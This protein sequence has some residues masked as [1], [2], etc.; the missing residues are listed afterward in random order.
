MG[1][2]WVHLD[3]QHVRTKRH[4]EKWIEIGVSFARWLPPNQ[5]TQR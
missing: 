4:L 1:P 3:A 5:P 2:G